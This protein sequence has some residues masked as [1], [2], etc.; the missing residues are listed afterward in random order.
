M[1]YKWFIGISMV[2]LGIF[3]LAT[4]K[5]TDPKHDKGA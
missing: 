1:D 3:F 2:I 5:E 4:G